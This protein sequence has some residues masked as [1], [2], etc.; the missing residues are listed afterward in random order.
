MGVGRWQSRA[1]WGSW[2]CH[3]A[4]LLGTPSVQGNAFILDASK[5]RLQLPAADRCERQI[6]SHG[7][8]STHLF[9]RLWCVRNMLASRVAFSP[10]PPSGMSPPLLVSVAIPSSLGHGY[11]EPT[12]PW[13]A[14]CPL[15]SPGTFCV[16]ITHLVLGMDFL[17]R[18]HLASC[19]YP[20]SPNRF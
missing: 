14:L 4:W 9:P 5:I 11:P 15:D 17:V 6:P 13:A 2:E 12:Q 16:S 20:I 1:P 18:Q 3:P 10:F 7:I 19:Q 8:H